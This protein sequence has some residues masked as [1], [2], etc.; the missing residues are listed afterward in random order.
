MLYRFRR[1]DCS[2]CDGLQRLNPAQPLLFAAMAAPATDPPLPPGLTRERLAQG[3]GTVVFSRDED[4]LLTVQKTLRARL[5]VFHATNI[6]RVV[7]ILTESR[8]GV[9]VA[10]IGTDREAIESMT[11]RLTAHLPELVT[12]AVAPGDDTG[13]LV[14]LVNQGR[15]FRFLRKPLSV[16]QCAISLQAALK[17]HRMLLKNPTQVRRELPANIDESAFMNGVSRTLTIVRRFWN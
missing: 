4:L 1:T 16:G 14:T 15:I 2:H 17:H 7:K 9:L 3:L 10:D 6:V 11:A 5:P 12:I 8:P 13:D